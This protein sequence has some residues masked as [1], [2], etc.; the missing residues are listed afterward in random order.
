M[1]IAMASQNVCDIRRSIL[2]DRTDSHRSPRCPLLKQITPIVLRACA[3][4]ADRVQNGLADHSHHFD[5]FFVGT[6][7]REE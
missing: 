5:R 1:T 3:E 6:R 7:G 4:R 2:I